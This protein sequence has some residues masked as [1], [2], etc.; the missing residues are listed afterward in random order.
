R[1]ASL[2]LTHD[3]DGEIRGLNEFRDERGVT[4]PPVAPLFFGF[5]IMVGT[6]MA[7]LVAAW[8]GCWLLRRR[9]WSPQSL[10]RPVLWALVPMTFSGWVATV[11]GW[12]VTEIGRQPYVVHGLVRTADVASTV[13]SSMI[14]L[15]LAMYVTLY[16][17][18]VVA[19]VAVIR[20]MAEQPAK[21]LADEATQRQAV[22]G[23]V[24]QA[25]S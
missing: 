11:A 17:A 20:Y 6:G 1:G 23:A 14:A 25:V 16:L 3:L 7:M 24:G 21:V 12:Y 10:P 18:L 5:R 8:A 4:H 2:I 13:P 15:T 22:A 9:G 19:Y